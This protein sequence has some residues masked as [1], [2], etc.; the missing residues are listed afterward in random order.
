VSQD[1]VETTRA[2]YALLNQEDTASL[3]DV[4]SPAFTMDFSRRL[5]D[6]GVFRGRAEVQAFWDR[7]DETWEQGTFGVQ[8]EQL[9]DAGDKVLVSVK[10]GGKGKTSGVEVETLVWLVWVFQDGVPLGLTYFGED[11]GAAFEE[12]GL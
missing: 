10:V 6:P 5:I 7:A 3:W 9:I 1:N 12:A 11:R 8:P 2:A 4:L